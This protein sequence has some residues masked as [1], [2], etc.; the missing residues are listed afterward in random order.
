MPLL[1]LTALGPQ[2]DFLLFHCLSYD[3]SVEPLPYPHTAL[4]GVW[5]SLPML[6]GSTAIFDR[7]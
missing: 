5:T 1:A 3:N 6:G 4:L 7:N 2:R